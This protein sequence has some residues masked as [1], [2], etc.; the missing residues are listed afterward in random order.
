MKTNCCYSKNIS[1]F[2]GSFV[3][4]NE[5]CSNY[6]SKT[7]LKRVSLP[8]RK[9]VVLSLVLISSLFSIENFS[10]KQQE[11]NIIPLH[12]IE[13]EVPF[14]VEALALELDKQ[15]VLCAEQV[16]AQM[17][18]ESGHFNSYLFK[19]THNLMGMRYPFSRPTSASGIYLP[20]R[21]TIITGPRDSLRQYSKIS[22][23]YAVYSSW[24]DAVQDYK[25]W[26]DYSFNLQNRYLEFL[27]RVY[28]EDEHYIHK[29]KQMTKR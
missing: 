3:C 27:G 7:S 26:Q 12:I 4:L 10:M 18:L 24:Q 11:H 23:T 15:G 19:H 5:S 21:D 29:L 13:K 28:A 14:S 17:R 16:L 22:N 8:G 1:N 6:L 9:R 25:Q 20:A 2:N